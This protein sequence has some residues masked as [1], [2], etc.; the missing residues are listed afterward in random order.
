MYILQPQ[1][2]KLKPEEAKKL[3]DK[4]NVSVSQ[5]PLIN[6]DDPSLPEGCEKGDII[7]IDRMEEE[8]VNIYFR[9]VV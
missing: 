9:V 1:H 3:L 4:Y 7:K 2:I 8:R 6:K 5:L